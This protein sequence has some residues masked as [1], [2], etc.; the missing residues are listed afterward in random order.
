MRAFLMTY[1]GRMFMLVL[2]N[3]VD[4]Y[5]N[6]ASSCLQWNGWVLHAGEVTPNKDVIVMWVNDHCEAFR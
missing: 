1:Y 2:L 6:N 5:K 3:S 4:M